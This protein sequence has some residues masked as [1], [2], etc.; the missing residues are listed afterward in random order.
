MSST[1]YTHDGAFGAP[2]IGT[3][4]EFRAALAPVWADWYRNADTASPLTEWIE[5]C[6]D[7]NL[8]EASPDLIARFERLPAVA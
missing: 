5:S 8:R 7:A 1:L 2:A 6:L 4:D 3:R